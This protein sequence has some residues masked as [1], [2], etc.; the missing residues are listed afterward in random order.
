MSF[1]GKSVIVTGASKGIGRAC[2]ELLARRG[3]EVVALGR[4]G[5]QLD[6]LRAEI[7]GRSITVDLSDPAAARWAMAEAGTC[8][9]LVN[10]AGTNVLEGVLEMTEAGYEAVL[11][12]NLRAALITSQEFARRRIAFWSSGCCR[13]RRAP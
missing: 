6:S 7:G 11:G 12:L 9:F 2:A 4:T 5:S 8:D 10:N 1:E 3:A 13:I